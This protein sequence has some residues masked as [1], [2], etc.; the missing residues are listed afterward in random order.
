[1]NYYVLNSND[2]IELFDTDKSKLQT[3]L[4]FKPDL[5]NKTIYET[6]R[7]IIE[8]DGKFVFADEHQEEISEQEALAEEQ[9]AYQENEEALADLKDRMVTAD[10]AGDDE[11][12]SELREEYSELM[13]NM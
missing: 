3:T 7:E 5:Q 4:K 11:W 13:E 9:Q 8:L 1:M 12:K 10:L 6:E 2:E